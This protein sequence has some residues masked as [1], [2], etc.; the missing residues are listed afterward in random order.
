MGREFHASRTADPRIEPL[1]YQQDVPH[2]F[3][4]RLGMR[5]RNMANGNGPR[6]PPERDAQLAPADTLPASVELRSENAN[7]NAHLQGPREH[8]D[9]SRQSHAT[10]HHVPFHPDSA[11]RSELL[12]PGSKMGPIT[13]SAG[14]ITFANAHLACPSW[15]GCFAGLSC[16]PGLLG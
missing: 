7:A 8:I 5:N 11:S 16:F 14:K 1:L 2:P 10:S 12:W 9:G 4:A 6:K 3:P 15:L 13:R